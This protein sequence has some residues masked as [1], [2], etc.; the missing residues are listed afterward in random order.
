MDKLDKTNKDKTTNVINAIMPF[1]TENC[2]K[3]KG[4][5]LEGY[6]SEKRDINV[7][8]IEDKV[9]TELKDI[10]RHA[11]NEELTFYDRGVRWDNQNLDI[12]GKQWVSAYLPVWLYSYQ[13]QKQVLHYVA[14]NA[15]TGAT[16]G[17]IPM[18]KVKIGLLA[19]IFLIIGLIGT[20][21]MN[22]WVPVIVGLIAAI[23][24]FFSKVSKYRNASARHTYEKDTKHEITNLQSVDNLLRRKTNL[25]N[26]S[27]T[28][29]NNK[30]VLGERVQVKKDEE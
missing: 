10:A 11:L 27:M 15:R 2:V 25:S 20:L 9:D 3:Y 28:G 22:S 23:V 21:A 1:D 5:Y 24:F 13:D 30:S 12:K 19:S 18:N 26:S 4:N 17:S 8:N 14:V 29:A 6:T 7:S 16:M